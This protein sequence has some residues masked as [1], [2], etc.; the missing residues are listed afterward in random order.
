MLKNFILSQRARNAYYLYS[1][2]ATYIGSGE[3]VK[4]NNMEENRSEYPAD[5]L[6]GDMR[7]KVKCRWV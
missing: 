3:E 5:C 2:V 6:S 4:E 1:G 7:G